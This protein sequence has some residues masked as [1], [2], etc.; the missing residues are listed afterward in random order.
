MSSQRYTILAWVWSLLLFWGCS[1]SLAG[2]SGSAI[3][4]PGTVPPRIVGASTTNHPDPVFG[5]TYALLRVDPMPQNESSPTS[6]AKE[7][8]L[9]GEPLHGAPLVVP[10]LLLVHG[11][12]EHGMADFF[13][14]LPRLA[15]DRTV[16]AVHLPGFGKSSRG[17]KVYSPDRYARFLAHVIEKHVEGGVVDVIGHSMGAAISI[18]LAG[19]YPTM[20]RRL[21]V[22]APAGMLYHETFV[23]E[24]NTTH[25]DRPET[26]LFRLLE[27]QLWKA[28]LSLLSAL[29][30]APTRVLNDRGLRQRVL[31]GESTQIAALALL[32]YNYDSDVRAVEAATLLLR[33][34]DDET[35]PARTFQLLRERLPVW[36]SHVLP[37]A[38]H[39]L[40]R[41]VPERL[42]PLLRTFLDTAYLGQRE[43][44]R[45]PFGPSR[46]GVCESHRAAVFEG[47]YH[48]IEIRSCAEV[49][50]RNAVVG[51]LSAENSNVELRHV[52]VER[53]VE[54]RGSNLRAT[55]SL[56]LG[57][58]ALVLDRSTADLAGVEVIGS[59]T[60]LVTQGGAQLVG[61]ISGF[62]GPRGRVVIHGKRDLAAGEHL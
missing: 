6:P 54:L 55:G 19:K 15:R 10:P 30:P 36:E 40:M 2:P 23:Y 5:G 11:V 50:I 26:S 62:T 7:R 18:T 16:L 34:Q 8:Q 17:N 13:P 60:A 27:R 39:N 58:Q 22:L 37:D 61:S 44:I 41:E 43:A 14:L 3:E 47:H 9:H 32:D 29:S 20:V 46:I 1:G 4:T 12:A 38:G 56:L 53:G 51:T 31:E 57:N 45:P 48:R 42:E 21:A 59:R 25:Q 49:L 35:A 24:M 52:T 28:G 33:G